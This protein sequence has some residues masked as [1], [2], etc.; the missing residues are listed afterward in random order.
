VRMYRKWAG[1]RDHPHR[2]REHG[3]AEAGVNRAQAPAPAC[4]QE[5]VPVT[6][7]PDFVT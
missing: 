6:V 7:D 1:D 2:P 4:L 3:S 5:V